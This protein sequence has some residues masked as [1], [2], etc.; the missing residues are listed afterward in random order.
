LDKITKI[1]AASHHKIDHTE[2]HWFHMQGQLQGWGYTVPK[3]WVTGAPPTQRRVAGRLDDQIECDRHC[4]L[5]KLESTN[6]L[7]RD[8]PP[9]ESDDCSRSRSD[10]STK[11]QPPRHRGSHVL[12]PVQWPVVEG[13]HPFARQLSSARSAPCR[14]NALLRAHPC[15]LRMPLERLATPSPA[16]RAP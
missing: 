10:E 3:E 7:A 14:R 8:G 11:C 15:T 2:Q 13:H 1:N 4:A 9:I 12:N 16:T 6:I 5:R